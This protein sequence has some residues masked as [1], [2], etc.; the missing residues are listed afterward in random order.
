MEIIKDI[1]N[2]LLGR[3]E[4]VAKLVSESSTPKRVEIKKTLAKKLKVDESL[5]IVNHIG[6][7]FGDSDIRVRAK[8]YNSEEALKKNARPHMVKRNAVANAAEEASE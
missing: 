7:Y 5:V 2:K 6:S 3:R 8:V 4:I 1:E